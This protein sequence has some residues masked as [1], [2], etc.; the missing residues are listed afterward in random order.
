M[1]SREKWEYLPRKIAYCQYIN[2]RWR[3]RIASR[4]DRVEMTREALRSGLQLVEI[5]IAFNRLI[6]DGR[7]TTP[8]G[9][10]GIILEGAEKDTGERRD[11]RCGQI[12]T[13]KT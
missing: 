3:Q 10:E 13:G 5:S 1:S 7:E 4:R 12:R 6:K 9:G 11:G 8:K 2:S